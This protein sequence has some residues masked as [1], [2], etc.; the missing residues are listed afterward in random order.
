MNRFRM[1]EFHETQYCPQCWRDGMT[2][3]LA[4]FVI[5]TDVYHQAVPF[6][7]KLLRQSGED[8]LIDLCSGNGLYMSQLLS[9]LKKLAPKR[10]LKAIL[11]DRYPTR[12]SVCEIG[13]LKNENVQYFH[14][15]IDALDALRKLPGLHVMFS[16]LH[17]FDEEELTALLQS[18]AS[19]RRPLAFFDYSR[20][21]LPAE[22]LPLLL[23]PL[24]IFL[25]APLIRPF[26]WRQLF[27]IY[28]VPVIPLLV[29]VDGFISRLRSYNCQELSEII[30]T[31]GDTPGYHWQSGKFISM[32]GL[33]SVRFIIG[34]PDFDKTGLP[35]SAD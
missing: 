28:V 3:F 17:H 25:L 19:N 2:N 31:L 10:D 22:I 35:A 29:M 34:T 21:N 24:L 26:S 23:A 30:K 11:T 12:S 9:S 8:T 20:R 5:H 18:A 33:C 32:M 7:D 27:F 16:A 13:K 15:A 4:F 14:E 6:V 1:K